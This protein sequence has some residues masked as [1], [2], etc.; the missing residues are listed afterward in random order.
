MTP[1]T[2][3]DHKHTSIVTI[4][5]DRSPV[6]V[7]PKSEKVPKRRGR[8]PLVK[9]ETI[10]NQLKRRGRPPKYPQERVEANKTDAISLNKNIITKTSNPITHIY[11]RRNRKSLS[12]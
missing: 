5:K 1:N 4:K 12:Q 7:L 6:Q 10:T 11:K 8:P 3:I 9:N 2:A